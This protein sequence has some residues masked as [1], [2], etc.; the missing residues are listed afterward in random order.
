VL[1]EQRLGPEE[2]NE[3]PVAGEFLHRLFVTGDVAA[4][5]PEDVEEGVPERFRLG[6]L[7]GLVF[8][9]LRE[10]NGA[11]LIS[12]QES[13]TGEFYWGVNP[14]S[15][16]IAGRRQATALGPWR[17]LFESPAGKLVLCACGFQKLNWSKRKRW[18]AVTCP[19]SPP[20]VSFN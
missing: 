9:F 15:R 7:A 1:G 13:G 16:R 5:L 19:R 12:F 6:L 14:V 18:G 2:I 10:G 20:C 11:V 17:G 3:A 4:L 8:P